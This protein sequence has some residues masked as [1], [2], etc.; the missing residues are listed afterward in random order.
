MEG[1]AWRCLEGVEENWTAFL[2]CGFWNLAFSFFRN[3]FRQ[4]DIRIY[5]GP[6]RSRSGLSTPRLRLPIPRPLKVTRHHVVA[7][8]L[9]QTEAGSSICDLIAPPETGWA[10]DMAGCRIGWTNGL[11][12]TGD[13]Q[14]QG[15]QDR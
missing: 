9:A 12:A 13:A 6:A 8:R 11:F 2:F 3:G 1:S 7:S 10:S 4:G 15:Q 5:R 14:E